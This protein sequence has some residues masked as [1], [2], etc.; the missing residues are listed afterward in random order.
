MVE[1]VLVKENEIENGKI[2]GQ[3]RRKIVNI[4]QTSLVGFNLSGF[5]AA[6]V[7]VFLNCQLHSSFLIFSFINFLSFNAFSF[8]FLYLLDWKV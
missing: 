2:S 8:S 3:S 4:L 1:Q 7:S 6:A 5:T